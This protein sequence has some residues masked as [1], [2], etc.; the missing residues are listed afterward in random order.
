MCRRILLLVFGVLVLSNLAWD[1]RRQDKE[2]ESLLTTSKVDMGITLHVVER[3]DANG[4]ALVP[5]NPEKLRVVETF[6]LGGMVEI[7]NDNGKTTARFSG[8]SVRPVVWHASRAQADLILHDG[9]IPWALVQG[10]EGSGKTTV[11]AKWSAVRV[12]E[13]IGFER[14][15]GI[16]APTGKR[17]NHVKREIRRYWPRHWFRWSVRDQKYTFHAGPIV[18]LV[19]AVQRSEDEGSPIQGANWVAHGG[20]ELQDHFEREADI[21]ARGRSA[22]NGNYRRLNTSTFKDSTGWRTFT[23]ACKA[24]TTD[25]HVTLLLGLESPFIATTHWERFRRGVT[26][27]EYQR[28][29]LAMDVGPERQLYYS[30]RRTLVSND[31]SKHE[32]RQPGNLRPLPIGA[33]DVTAR[34]LARFGRNV[35]LLLGHDPGKRQH[36]TEFLKAYEF[37]ENR[38]DV[39]GRPLL[40]VV[41][42]FVVDEITSVEKTMETH[43]REVL[44]R[45]QSKWRCMLQDSYSGAMSTNCPTALV[46][47]DPHTPTGNEHPDRVVYSQWR[48]AGFHAMAAAYNAQTQRPTPI[49]VDARVDLINTLLCDTDGERRLFVLCDDQGTPVAPKLVAAFESMERNEQ[50][51]AEWERKDGS[52]LSHWPCSVAFAVWSIEKPRV[53]AL[54]ARAA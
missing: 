42:W 40:P 20:D 32:T 7:A 1:E 15:I 9:P 24:N 19:S 21:V 6:N 18:Q 10:S 11:L 54:R 31:N 51:D 3:D 22:P 44:A 38:R 36:V 49:K 43:I 53:D 41:R 52:D 4:R 28:R 46:R 37:P 47:I 17:L 50:N 25:W 26:L 45:V 30:W 27:R 33:V 48:N 35:G 39:N 23:A 34:E 14:E 12:L 8:P 5:G 29:V 13:H 2:V 16:T